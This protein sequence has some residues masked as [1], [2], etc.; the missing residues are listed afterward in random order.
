[1]GRALSLTYSSRGPHFSSSPLCSCGIWWKS[2][3]IGLRLLPTSCARRSASTAPCA[4]A[5]PPQRCCGRSAAPRL[6]Q[7]LHVHC[8]CAGL[9]SCREW[10]EL[11][12]PKTI[13]PR[14]ANFILTG[15]VDGKEDEEGGP[16]ALLG[17]E[18]AGSAGCPLVDLRQVHGCKCPGHLPWA[19]PATLA[20]TT[21]P[22]PSIAGAGGMR[23][24]DI[25][26]LLRAHCDEAVR[27]YVEDVLKLRYQ[28]CCAVQACW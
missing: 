11:D 6:P 2:R 24:Q 28:V 23:K 3:R 13:A 21:H 12:K 25:K 8:C 26:E 1:M 20:A 27:S 14:L 16:A 4:P 10:V 9:P 18:A 17:R 22:C 19:S 5:G 15:D 7:Q